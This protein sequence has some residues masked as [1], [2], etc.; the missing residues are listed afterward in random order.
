MA[1]VDLKLDDLTVPELISAGGRLADGL[2]NNANFPDPSPTAI[3]IEA[4]VQKLTAAQ[5]EYRVHRNRLAE[6]NATRDAIADDLKAA[7][8][9]GAAYVQAASDGD[10]EKILSANLHVEHGFSM[11]PFGSL[12]QV[13]EL[14]ASAGDQPGEIDL[15]WDPVPG[16]AGYEVEISRDIAPYGPWEQAAAT[17][18]SKT[19]L[20]QLT[21]KQRYWIRVRAVTD[22]KTG[23]WSDPVMKSAP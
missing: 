2:T 6:L 19:T 7:L 3:D 15:T 13:D 9:Q 1:D 18:Q 17:G 22:D 12:D 8:A 16:A 5:E 10:A 11:W 4:L 23:D 14:S 20:E 21:R